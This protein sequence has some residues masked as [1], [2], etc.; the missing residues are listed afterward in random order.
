MILKSE[1]RTAIPLGR[2]LQLAILR[3]CRMLRCDPTIKEE[4]L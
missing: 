4:S 3:E 2:L 1:L